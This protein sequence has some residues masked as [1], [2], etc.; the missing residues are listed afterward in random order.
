MFLWG[1]IVV[2][3]LRQPFKRFTRVKQFLLLPDSSLQP[4]FIQNIG[5]HLSFKGSV[6]RSKF[7]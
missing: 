1:Y 5:S 7:S 3:Q 4:S 6:S 2:A